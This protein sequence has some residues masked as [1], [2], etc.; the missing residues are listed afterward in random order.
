M[1]FGDGENDDKNPNAIRSLKQSV[2]E[3]AGNSRVLSVLLVGVTSKSWNDVQA[4][5]SPLGS[6][7][8][9]FN[10]NDFDGDKL[11]GAVRG[12]RPE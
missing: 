4:I 2:E 7:L 12:V 11:V 1:V 5:F 3:L 8:R 9:I 6:R 10:P